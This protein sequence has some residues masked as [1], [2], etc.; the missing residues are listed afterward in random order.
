MFNTFHLLIILR[1]RVVEYNKCGEEREIEGWRDRGV[2]RNRLTRI[3][4]IVTYMYKS[5]N[6]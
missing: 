1:T 5:Y 2:E 4:W 3:G 6:Y